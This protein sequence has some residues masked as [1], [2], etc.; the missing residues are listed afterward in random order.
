MSMNSRPMTGPK[1]PK[2]TG[3]V[4]YAQRALGRAES[5]IYAAD[6]LPPIS[7]E[8]HFSAS[9]ATTTTVSLHVDHSLR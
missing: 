1:K 2:R 3:R 4:A 7:S 9:S 6:C 8:S 5:I